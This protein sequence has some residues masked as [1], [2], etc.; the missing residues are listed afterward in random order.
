MKD[1]RI[2]GWIQKTDLKA[3]ISI[4]WST[5]EVGKTRFHH[6]YV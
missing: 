3:G 4:I 6:L 5:E 1:M 2:S